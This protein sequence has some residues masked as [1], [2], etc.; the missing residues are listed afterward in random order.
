MRAWL[1]VTRSESRGVNTTCSCHGH[2]L[3]VSDVGDPQQIASGVFGD[4]E[5]ALTRGDVEERR[6]EPTATSVWCA[7]FQHHHPASSRRRCASKHH[8]N[9]LGGVVAFHFKGSRRTRKRPSRTLV[10]FRADLPLNG[11]TISTGPRRRHW[12]A[13][14]QSF[15]KAPQQELSVLHQR[16]A[17]RRSSSLRSQN[18]G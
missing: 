10:V 3:D 7:Y 11:C 12:S 4:N 17:R 9:I 1:R 5:P 13:P 8:R 2:Q 14:G 6:L 18:R 15:C 16:G